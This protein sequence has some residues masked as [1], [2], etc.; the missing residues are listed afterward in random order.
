MRSI[1]S[2]MMGLAEN[3]MKRIAAL[4][5]ISSPNTVGRRKDKLLKNVILDEMRRMTRRP[6]YS[7][8]VCREAPV[9]KRRSM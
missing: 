7:A 2:L 4:N 5:V 8:A 6:A 3:G 1:N 9:P